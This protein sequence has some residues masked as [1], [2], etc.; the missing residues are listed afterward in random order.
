M[1][2]DCTEI[3]VPARLDALP[4]LLAKV[5]AATT[6]LGDDTRRRIRIVLE[7][8]FLNSVH[9]GQAGGTEA[10]I[11]VGVCPGPAGVT[12]TYRDHA[13]PFDPTANPAV[14]RLESVGGFGLALIRNLAQAVRYRRE[15]DTNCVEL[16][17]SASR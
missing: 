5:D 6:G 8:L 16:D 4:A 14:P 17:F 12:L 13:P 9:H 11:V 1:P 15:S 7:E 3:S 10:P 2:K